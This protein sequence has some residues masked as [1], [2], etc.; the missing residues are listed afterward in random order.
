MGLLPCDLSQKLEAEDYE[1]AEEYQVLD[2]MECGCCAY[3]CPARRPLV[4]HLRQGKAWVMRKRR[5]A[6]EKEAQAAKA[7]A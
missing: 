2:C 3:T 1:G 7:K 6:K 5:E 4:Q